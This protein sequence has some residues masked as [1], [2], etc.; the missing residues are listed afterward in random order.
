MFQKQVKN[1]CWVPTHFVIRVHFHG[2]YKYRQ[3]LKASPI[4]AA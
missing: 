4:K 3:S 1:T 2:P